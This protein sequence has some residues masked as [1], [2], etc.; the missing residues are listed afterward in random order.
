[1]IEEEGKCRAE[2]EARGLPVQGGREET[3]RRAGQEEKRARGS[4]YYSFFHRGE[5]VATFDRSKSRTWA[6]ISNDAASCMHTHGRDWRLGSSC[7]SWSSFLL[8]NYGQHPRPLESMWPTPF[9][10][11]K[12]YRK[13]K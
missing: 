12:K 7:C 1:M 8:T 5:G 6:C 4:S 2:A 9:R 3:G 13:K 10:K 11:I